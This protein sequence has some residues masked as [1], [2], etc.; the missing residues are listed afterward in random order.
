MPAG[1]PAH[2]ALAGP[3]GENASATKTRLRV[4]T[5]TAESSFSQTEECNPYYIVNYGCIMIAISIH[6][7]WTYSGSSASSWHT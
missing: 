6:T 7:R 5:H 3:H 4:H 2:V 1:V